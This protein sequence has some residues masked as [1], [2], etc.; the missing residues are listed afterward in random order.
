MKIVAT[1]DIH[2][3]LLDSV[4]LEN[5]FFHFLES[6]KT[7]KADVLVIAGDVVGL[8]W[9]RLEEC[10]EL[11]RPMAPLRIMVFGNHEHWAA[12]KNTFNHLERLEKTIEDSG[13]VLLDKKP[14]KLGKVGFVGNCGWYDYSF[15]EK[16]ILPGTVFEKKE[17]L[18]RVVWNDANFVG[19]NQSDP[20]YTNELIE[21]L[22]KD[23]KGMERH[24]E[25]IVAVTH[26]PGFQEML[27]DKPE[28]KLW[29]FTNAFMGSKKL[30][31]MLLKHPKVKY[32]ICGHSHH[33]CRIKKGH[34][35]SIN[36]GSTYTKKRYTTLKIK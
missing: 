33:P 24:V 28:D 17:F 32:H 31:E 1:C 7:E 3:D 27:T 19:L 14:I 5:D 36:P 8:G 13:V 29:A 9:T 12:D 30:G 21:K 25:T 15:A 16:P 11:F 6:M 34:L 10:L 20:E 35:E 4:K 2:Y 26:H 18:G 23:I 22:E